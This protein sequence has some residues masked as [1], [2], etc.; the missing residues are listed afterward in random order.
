MIACILIFHYVLT[1]NFE[2]VATNLLK[3]DLHPTDILS[4]GHKVITLSEMIPRGATYEAIL[5][6]H[7]F[8][9]L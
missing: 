4:L 5:L 3:I 9:L 7:M 6:Q 1:S 2:G 8:I